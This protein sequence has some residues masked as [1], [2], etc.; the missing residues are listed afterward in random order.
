MAISSPKE[1][2][3]L[4]ILKLFIY[5]NITL[6][7]LVYSPLL[8][9]IANEPTIT[10]RHTEVHMPGTIIYV[11]TPDELLTALGTATGGETIYLRS[12]NYGDIS[13]SNLHFT[14]MVTIASEDSL[15][16]T[17][18]GMIINSSDNLRLDNVEVENIL[19]PDEPDWTIA[20]SINGSSNI[21][22]INSDLHG[23]ID[24]NYNNDGF[25]LNVKDS[26]NLLLSNNSFH[27]ANKAAL[28]YT[29]DGV[30]I[31]NNDIYDIRSDG[32]DFI[33]VVN[34]N[35]I[36]N[37]FINFHPASGD[38]AD[39]IQFWN[40]GSPVSSGNVTITNNTFLQGSG[41]EFQSIFISDH[42]GLPYYNFTISENVIYNGSPHGITAFA[43]TD[44]II[45]NNTLLKSPTGQHVPVILIG[46]PA[47][48]IQ[49]SNN[50]STLRLD[51]STFVTS[52]NNIEPQ[53]VDSTLPTYYGNLFFDAFSGASAIVEDFIPLPGSLLNSGT[54]IGAFA[55]SSITDTLQA[56]ASSET[57]YGTADGLK[58]TF[59]GSHTTDIDGNPGDVGVTYQWDFGDGTT[60][61]GMVVNHTY[62]EER[63]F[64]ATL[65]VTRNGASDNTTHTVTT[66]DP[67]LIQI[68]DASSPD[69]VS[70]APNMTAAD[71]S[72]Q[73][74]GSGYVNLGR[75]AELFGL[76]QMHISFD[77]KAT[78]LSSGSGTL[79]YSHERYAI[80]LNGDALTF[81]MFTG[82]GT[83]NA[84]TIDNTSILDGQSHNIAMSFDSATGIIT[85]FIDNA[86]AGSLP[87]VVGSIAG[88]GHWD[89]VLGGTLWGDYFNGELDNVN[90]WS[91]TEPVVAPTVPITSTTDTTPT[92]EP[93]LDT[94]TFVEPVI[95]TDTPEPEVTTT[96]TNSSITTAT[97]QDVSIATTSN[98]NPTTTT[99]EPTLDTTTFVEP[100]I[101]NITTGPEVT[102]TY[103]NSSITT[104]STQDEP[105]ATTFTPLGDAS[106]T[107]DTLILSG[108]GYID[109][110]QDTSLAG[111]DAFTINMD[112]TADTSSNDN[113]GAV[114]LMWNQERFGIELENNDI[115][116]RLQTDTGD[117]QVLRAADVNVNDGASHNIIMG[118]DS[119]TGIMSGYVDNELVAEA[120]GM[121]GRI[122]DG[123]SESVTVGGSALGRNF[124]GEIGNVN[125]WSDA[126][127]IPNSSYSSPSFTID[128]GLAATTIVTSSIDLTALGASSLS[129]ALGA[130]TDNAEY[131]PDDY[132]DL[133]SN[134]TPLI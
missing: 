110:G 55:Y 32:F 21:E 57:Y 99:T 130:A 41:D 37:D 100:V 77:I 117:T 84:L 42:A 82:E 61:E 69:I 83:R 5:I 38:H 49:V 63:D 125:L 2:T 123:N 91:A 127:H 59:D 8:V 14:S 133:L 34:L 9:L 93:V 104:A 94:T 64:T 56:Q 16:A 4:I 108:G 54:F 78:E 66:A 115:I 39:A 121:T 95:T 97:T 132:W 74:D 122:A 6:T 124:K 53:N 129:N 27:D 67:H 45:T 98:T 43:G 103:T 81:A 18:T 128:E 126:D 47:G 119:T 68:T 131:N 87:G 60:G 28:I 118:Y 51:I 70:L 26:S 44:F 24:G 73:F 111:L 75:S 71:S 40:N 120:T 112:V 96:Y 72:L 35:I 7:L 107:G 114:R 89:V 13:L 86:E 3:Q 1:G 88:V 65:T 48:P 102:S 36:G 105:I 58:V 50:V 15:G 134:H 92:T 106:V 90:I 113:L 79:L 109:L 85:V 52:S 29:S 62:A 23:S 46:D 80:S 22:I 101:T 76:D 12:G 30:Q 20:V 10:F 33:G 19:N 31:L 25:I 116:F 17:F 11:S